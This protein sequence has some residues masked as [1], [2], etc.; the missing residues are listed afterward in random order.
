V[1][2]TRRD[3]NRDRVIAQRKKKK[4]ERRIHLPPDWKFQIRFQFGERSALCESERRERGKRSRKTY[5]PGIVWSQ[6]DYEITLRSTTIGIKKRKGK[7]R[8]K[9]RRSK[10][11]SGGLIATVFRQRMLRQRARLR[12][13]GEDGRTGGGEPRREGRETRVTDTECCGNSAIG[14]SVAGSSS[15]RS[16]GTPGNRSGQTRLEK[17]HLAGLARSRGDGPRSLGDG[18]TNMGRAR[19]RNAC[20]AFSTNGSAPFPDGRIGDTR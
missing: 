10:R 17:R 4:K 20:L 9:K 19:A 16:I 5:D 6:R 13:A 1:T 7:E 15:R 12:S 2:C 11:I 3:R 18:L 8:R 14:G